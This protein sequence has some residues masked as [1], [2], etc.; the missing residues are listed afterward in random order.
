MREV[1]RCSLREAVSATAQ[2]AGGWIW[3]SIGLDLGPGRPYSLA[4][5]F[6]QPLFTL[7][8]LLNYSC[9]A[10]ILEEKGRETEE[11]GREEGREGKK[12]GR[13]EERREKGR[14][15]KG[16]RNKMKQKGKKRKGFTLDPGSGQPDQLSCWGDVER[17]GEGG[18]PGCYEP[19]P[20]E[21]V[22]WAV[23]SLPE[24]GLSCARAE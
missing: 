5:T 17:M 20:C 14:K 9:H 6:Q 11:R 23:L 2:G 18:V 16:K 15:R 8:W 1:I 22:R 7:Q 10:H 13:K 19:L 21:S 24:L 12:E 3:A 4:G